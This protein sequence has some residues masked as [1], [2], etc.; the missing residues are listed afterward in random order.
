MHHPRLD[1]DSDSDSEQDCFS[2]EE[3]FVTKKFFISLLPYA[4]QI[5]AQQGYLKKT[6]DIRV[7]LRYIERSFVPRKYLSDPKLFKKANKLL[8][9]LKA[10]IETKFDLLYW[11]GS[12]YQNLF[13]GY[14]FLDHFTL[15]PE[16]LRDIIEV[17][18]PDELV[19]C[20]YVV[21]KIEDYDL[22]NAEYQKTLGERRKIVS[23]MTKGRKTVD[24]N[25]MIRPV[26]KKKYEDEESL[27]ADLYQ[28]YLHWFKS[29][30]ASREL[31]RSIR[32]KLIMEGVVFPL[33]TVPEEKVHRK[34]YLDLDRF[35]R[36]VLSDLKNIPKRF[37]RI[38]KFC[39]STRLQKAAHIDTVSESILR[40]VVVRKEGNSNAFKYPIFQEVCKYMV[41]P[42][43]LNWA[44]QVTRHMIKQKYLDGFQWT[45]RDEKRPGRY[46]GN[47]TRQFKVSK[48]IWLRKISEIYLNNFFDATGNDELCKLME[49]FTGRECLPLMFNDLFDVLDQSGI[50]WTEIDLKSAKREAEA[51]TRKV[52]AWL[53]KDMS[54]AQK[55]QRQLLK[56]GYLSRSDVLMETDPNMTD[57]AE[58]FTRPAVVRSLIT[59]GEGTL[60]NHLEFTSKSYNHIANCER[61]QGFCC[62]DMYQLGKIHK[63]EPKEVLCIHSD[64][65]PY[66]K[67]KEDSNQEYTDFRDFLEEGN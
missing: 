23:K 64:L 5:K 22:P 18:D 51:K 42:K 4:K 54:L 58:F 29:K 60:G 19:T 15:E 44:T 32:E 55:M 25:I 45:W 24:K 67:G 48:A 27:F 21:K 12:R 33:A 1:S 31:F 17:N 65:K 7:V 46:T 52:V 14:T 9:S 11:T 61:C 66:F 63:Y 20:S 56:D 6:S 10:Y 37:W 41:N 53:T 28:I 16:P 2:D 30:K 36:Y 62:S 35:Q 47:R 13:T 40:E 39:Q 59:L 38:I 26:L 50:S 3:D 49:S 34:Y 43:V 8:Y 57:Q